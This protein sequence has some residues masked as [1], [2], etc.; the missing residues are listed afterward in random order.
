MG[1]GDGILFKWVYEVISIKFV[2]GKVLD[3]YLV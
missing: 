1:C 2:R 3:K